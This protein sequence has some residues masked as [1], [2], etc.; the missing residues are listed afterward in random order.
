M[1][2]RR[3]FETKIPQVT[4]SP[5]IPLFKNFQKKWFDIDSSNFIS[6]LE[7]QYCSSATGNIKKDIL[8]F[9]SQLEIKNARDDY[10][11]LSELVL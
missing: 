6:G 5:S 8:N 7:D 3:V 4:T 11:E 10:N 2:L 1:V 9:V